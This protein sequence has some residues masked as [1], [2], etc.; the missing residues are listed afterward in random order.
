M[1]ARYE[2]DEEARKASG[3]ADS[4]YNTIFERLE[5]EGGDVRLV[6]EIGI[7]I[8]VLTNVYRGNEFLSR[9]SSITCC[10]HMASLLK[11]PHR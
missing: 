4:T 7:A 8:L 2:E 11:L 9:T 5:Q 3:F 10:L 1:G 6:Q